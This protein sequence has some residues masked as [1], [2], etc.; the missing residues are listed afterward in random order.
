[1]ARPKRNAAQLALVN[2]RPLVIIESPLRGLTKAEMVENKAY[3]RAA[4]H[5]SLIRNEAP[6]ASH[7]FYT[8]FLDDSSTFEREVGLACAWIFIGRADLIAVYND[9]GISSGMQRGI[10]L[11]KALRKPIVLRSLGPTWAAKSPEEA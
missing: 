9:F 8:Q 11:A 1:M 2:A 4:I 7:G 10:D 3:L 5:D 6:F